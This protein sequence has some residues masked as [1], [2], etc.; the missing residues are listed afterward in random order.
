MLLTFIF[1]YVN[2]FTASKLMSSFSV[3]LSYVICSD[4]WMY[5]TRDWCVI[6]CGLTQTRFAV[7]ACQ[8]AAFLNA[9]IKKGGMRVEKRDEGWTGVEKRKLFSA[10]LPSPSPS[11]TFFWREGRGLSFQLSCNNTHANT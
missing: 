4:P 1:I 2:P 6:Y 9:F 8:Q 11:S 3:L 7:P 5:Q 10:P